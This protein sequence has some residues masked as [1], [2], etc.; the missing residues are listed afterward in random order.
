MTVRTHL[1]RAALTGAAVVV[2]L[3]TGQA[4]HADT[5]SVRRSATVEWLQLGSVPQAAGNVHVGRVQAWVPS[6]TQQVESVYGESFDY[7]CPAGF[8]PDGLWL[9]AIAQLDASCTLEDNLIMETGELRLHVQGQLHKARLT[10]ALGYIHGYA[11]GDP[12]T[13]PLDLTWD[14]PGGKDVVR[15]QVGSRP[16]AFEITTTRQA[17]VSGTIGS[18]PVG[19]ADQTS[20]GVLQRIKTVQRG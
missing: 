7:T 14:A 1:R 3:A 17:T 8:V 4:A 12:G 13:I 20:A 15:Q 2:V 16:N 11:V 9:D 5:I 6:G 10:G 18:G 19:P